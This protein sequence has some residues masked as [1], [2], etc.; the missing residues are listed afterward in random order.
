MASIID[1]LLGRTDLAVVPAIMEPEAKAAIGPGVASLTYGTPLHSLSRDPHRLMAEAQALFHTN[2]WVAAAERALGGRFVRMPWHLEDENGDTIDER[3][4]ARLQVPLK[5]LQRPNQYK[6]RAQVWG[7]TFRHEGL[8]G[9]GF[10]YLDQREP[11]AGTPLELLYINPARMT[12]VTNTAGYVQ[13]WILDHPENQV[14]NRLGASHQ[15]EGIPL[16]REEVIHFCFDEPDW[17]VWGVG[18]PE[19]AQRKIELDRLTDAHA[20]GVLGSGGRLAGLITPKAGVTVQDDQWVQFVRDWRSITSDPDAAKR[21]QIGK[22]PLD[23][24]QMTAS[25]KDLQLIDVTKQTKEDILALWGVPLS[26]LGINVT[27]GLNADRSEADDAAIWETVKQRSEP[28]REKIQYELLDRWQAVGVKVTLIFDYPEFDDRAP[29]F[30]AVAKSVNAAITNDERRNIL[31]LEPLE[32]E[33]LGKAIYIHS[34]LVRIDEEPAPEVPAPP[35][36]LPP[37]AT[38]EEVEVIEGKADL[39]KP[40]LGLRSKTET[41]WEPK[42]RRVISEVLGEQ[43]RYIASRAEHVA[44]KPSDI[45]SWWNDK[46]EHRRFMTALEP[47]I[48]DMA[49]EVAQQTTRTVKKPEGKADTWLERVLEAVRSSVGSR[50]TGINRT[51]REKVQAAIAEGVELGESPADLGQRLRSSAA[52]DEYRSELISRTETAQVYNDAALRSYGELEV[53]EVEAI[54]GD[55]DAECAARNGKRYPIDE[56]MGISDHPNG[57]LDWVPV[58]KASLTP[59]RRPATDDMASLRQ[60]I[61]QAFARLQNPIINVTLPES[62][63]TLPADIRIVSMPNRI[64]HAIRKPDGTIEGS[65]EGDA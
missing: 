6:T 64:H 40:L 2:G 54:D 28:F 58:V 16:T 49:T 13:G 50:I 62:K 37:V 1:R 44:R 56:A 9:N 21:L 61:E 26:Q 30:E 41:T 18:I 29:L 3:S 47:T 12:P 52:F 4:D 55:E 33:Q 65:M 63:A 57:T 5:L 23:F 8:A 31:G 11:V 22:M 7:L 14:L 10:W 39:T 34:S 19:S 51:T 17:G 43:R 35:P 48:I 15:R 60:T 38:D 46:R 36:M 32:D 45:S 24:T 42:L 25:P 20:G 59:V 27:A 53:K